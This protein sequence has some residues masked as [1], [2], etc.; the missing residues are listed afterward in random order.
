V[1]YGDNNQILTSKN[2]FSGNILSKEQLAT[3]PMEKI[4]AAMANQFGGALDN[5]D[6]APGKAVPFMIVISKLPEGAKNFGA[7]PAGSAAVTKPK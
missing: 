7:L 4:E 3:M 1:V 6:V 2:V 5:L